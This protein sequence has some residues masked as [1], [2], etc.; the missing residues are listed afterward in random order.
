[1]S[2]RVEAVEPAAAGEGWARHIA[3]VL[4]M[5]STIG[6]GIVNLA[7]SLAA[8][9][10]ITSLLVDLTTVARSRS[11]CCPARALSRASPRRG[12]RLRTPRL[13]E[14]DRCAAVSWSG[15]RRHQSGRFGAA[16]DGKP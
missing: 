7:T 15:Y 13:R 5:G 8:Y 3:S 1:M 2:G 11:P 10:P 16:G 9:G 14:R 6:V 12:A 4:I